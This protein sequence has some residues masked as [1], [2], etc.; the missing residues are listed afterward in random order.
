MEEVGIRNRGRKRRRRDDCRRHEQQHQQ[1]NNHGNTDTQL[2]DDEDIA[3]IHRKIQEEF[4]THAA[5]TTCYTQ[6]HS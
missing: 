3:A 5:A 1:G 6:L 4:E 2:T